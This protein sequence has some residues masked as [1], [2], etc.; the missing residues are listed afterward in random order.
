MQICYLQQCESLS[1]CPLHFEA[2]RSGLEKAV[3]FVGDWLQSKHTSF[4]YI[5]L[6]P[7]RFPQSRWLNEEQE[8][9]IK[10][11]HALLPLVAGPFT[12]YTT[13]Y[14]VY[15]WGWMQRSMQISSRGVSPSENWT[16]KC[17]TWVC[18]VYLGLR[19]LLAV[20]LL[21]CMEKHNLLPKGPQGEHA[22]RTGIFLHTIAIQSQPR[23][24]K[25]VTHTRPSYL[26][27]SEELVQSQVLLPFSLTVRAE[28]PTTCSLA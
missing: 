28:D 19:M 12:T 13:F 6:R 17:D 18:D 3:R 4:G 23:A 16:R 14:M 1:R 15:S 8:I 5:Q 25:P 26:R 24:F 21:I 9:I 22:D 2:M 20:L 11:A 10:G 27:P 7:S